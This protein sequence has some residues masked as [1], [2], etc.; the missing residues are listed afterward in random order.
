MVFLYELYM[1]SKQSRSTTCNTP[2]TTF[3]I[4]SE[5]EIGTK[6]ILAATHERQRNCKSTY[7]FSNSFTRGLYRLSAYY[8]N[9]L[10]SLASR[11]TFHELL[12]LIG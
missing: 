8:I 10:S 6:K 11:H 4:G 2:C 3:A 7:F 1:N 5:G 12:G 9:F